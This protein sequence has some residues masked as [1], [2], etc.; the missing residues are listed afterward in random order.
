MKTQFLTLTLMALLP[1]ISFAKVADFNTLISENS[2]A[3]KELHSTVKQNVQEARDAASLDLTKRE[4]MVFVDKER[5][6][7]NSPTKKDMLVY[8]K[9]K[10]FHRSS[11]EKRLEL[12]ANELSHI[13]E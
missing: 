5:G 8:Q 1:T 6:T 7:I 2:K 13:D 9:E 12:L 11:E 3:Q 4:R 10:T